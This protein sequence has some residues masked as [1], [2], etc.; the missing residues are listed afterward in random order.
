MMPFLVQQQYH[1]FLLKG[2]TG[3]GKTQVY[4]E[5]ARRVRAAGRS[6][7]VLVPE[8]ALTG[9]VVLAFKA[10]FPD[11]LVVMHSRLSLAERNDASSACAVGRRASSSRA[12]GTLYAGQ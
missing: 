1:G 7:I 5:M 10:Y 12:F 9:Q 4:I 3:S 2:V 8:I 11:D 6:V